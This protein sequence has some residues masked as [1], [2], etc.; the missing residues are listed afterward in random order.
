M[1][2]RRVLKN[3]K[4]NAELI[5]SIRTGFLDANNFQMQVQSI[6]GGKVVCAFSVTRLGNLLH[7]RQ[8]LN[9]PGNNY[10]AQNA[11]KFYAIFVQLSK[12]FI[13]IAKSFLGRFYSHLATFY[14]SHCAPST[15]PMIPMGRL[16]SKYA[17]KHTYTKDHSVIFV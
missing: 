1:V 2:K 11:N 3:V 16:K 9:A 13:L 15:Y 5:D 17:F 12:Y 10:F 8:L 6:R 14:W 7:F 4:Y